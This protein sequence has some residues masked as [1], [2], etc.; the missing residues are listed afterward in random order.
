VPDGYA[1]DFIRVLVNPHPFKY[2]V[3]LKASVFDAETHQPISGAAVNAALASGKTDQAGQCVLTGVPAGLVV[4]IASSPG[5]DDAVAPVDLVAGQNG[6][7]RMELHRHGESTADLAK[8][9]ATNGSA[10]IYGIHFD[11]NQATLQAASQ[12][13]LD[14]ILSLI[15]GQAGSRWIIAGHTDNKGGAEYNLRLSRARADAVVGWLT[16]HG[17]AQSRL[18]AQG[19][20]ANKPVADNATEGG[21]ALNRRVEIEPIKA[22]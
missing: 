2:Q 11:T 13:A 6:E 14:A 10:A 4:A 3:S 5:Y 1:V 18:V 17:V 19:F 8:S 22:Q 9:I 12:P 15:N 16:A 20:G 7:T 21:Q